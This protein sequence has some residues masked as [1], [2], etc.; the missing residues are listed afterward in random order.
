MSTGFHRSAISATIP[1]GTALSNIVDLQESRLVGIEM[2]AAW[3]AA[4]LTFRGGAGTSSS[5]SAP[6][7]QDVYDDAAELTLTGGAARVVLFNPGTNVDRLMPRYVQVRSGTA[8]APV[9]Q[10]ADRVIRL[11]LASEA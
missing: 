4:D 1:N 11:L 10:G 8:A 6:T 9:N 5:E 7:V 3:T 2:P